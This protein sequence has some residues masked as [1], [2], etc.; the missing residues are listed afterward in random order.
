MRLKFRVGL[1]E[2]AIDSYTISEEH[3]AL[4]SKGIYFTNRGGFNEITRHKDLS[5]STKESPLFLNWVLMGNIF[6]VTESPSGS[7]SLAGKVIRKSYDSHYVLVTERKDSFTPFNPRSED[8]LDFHY[9]N[10]VVSNKDQILPHYAVY[11][12]SR[13][14]HRFFDKIT[15]FIV[16]IDSDRDR[17]REIF[18]KITKILGAH[19]LRFY[20]ISSFKSWL[21]HESGPLVPDKSQCFIVCASHV[22]SD[23]TAGLRLCIWLRSSPVYSQCPFILFC[24]NA[25]DT[26]FFRTSVESMLFAT[27]DESVIYEYLKTDIFS[28]S[29]QIGRTKRPSMKKVPSIGFG[30]PKSS[31]TPSEKN[32]KFSSPRSA[33]NLFSPKS[34][35]GG[36]K[37]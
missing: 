6:P 25:T 19:F 32:S 9:D 18:T 1:I 28:G 24:R 8:N 11:Y 7:H 4:F 20:S 27:E 35:Y 3:H 36:A 5:Q 2:I 29:D 14:I 15:K 26:L 37:K 31:R 30:T 33:I 23:E 22:H 16:W 34:Y 13:N 10:T 12:T 21:I 17:G